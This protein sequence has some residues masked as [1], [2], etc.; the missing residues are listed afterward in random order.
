MQ[1]LART[2]TRSLSPP[3]HSSSVPARLAP[4]Q[5]RRAQWIGTSAPC[6]T[7]RGAPVQVRGARS[8]NRGVTWV[9]RGM[10]VVGSFWLAIAVVP[11][12]LI[13]GALIVGVTAVVLEARPTPWA[14]VAVLVALDL[15]WVAATIGIV[16]LVVRR[17]RRA[18]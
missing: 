3:P 2:R 6:A 4:D 17:K 1:V 16:V 9:R 12:W 15:A 10:L 18:Q 5:G 8:D 14:A 11:G 13:G 7:S